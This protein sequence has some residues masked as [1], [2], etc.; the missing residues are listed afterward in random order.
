MRAF[1]YAATEE[2]DVSIMRIN[3]IIIFARRD[4]IIIKYKFDY[5]DNDLYA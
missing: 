4:V 2:K 5:N 3:Y 1:Q